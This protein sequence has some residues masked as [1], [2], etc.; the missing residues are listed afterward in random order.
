[1]TAQTTLTQR[2]GQV[3]SNTYGTPPVAIVSGKGATVTDEDGKE[4]I[5]MLAGIAVNSLGYAHPAIVEAVSTQ[6]AT[7]GHVSNLFASKPVVEAAGKLLE[8]VGDSDA[9]VFFSNSG[10][11]ANEAAFK[12]ARLTGRRRIL[13]AHHGFHGRTMGSLA[14]TGQPA[15]RKAFEPFPGGVEFYTYGDID[16]LT[17]LVEQNPEDTSAIILEPIQGET[18][19][20]PAPD[21][22]LSAVRELCTKHGI[23]MIVDEV[24]TGVG[25]TGDFFAFQHE[26]VLPDVITMAKG[27][28]AGMPIGA[29]IARGQ[30]KDLF[31]PGSHGTT[32]GGN[33]VS[34]AAAAT[35]LELVD[36]PFLADVSRKGEWLRTEL[37]QSPAVQSVR[38]RGLMLGVVLNKSVAKDVVAA[39]LQH[40]L[41][42]NAPSS[43][44]V[45]L[46]PPLVITDEELAQAVERLHK[47]LEDFG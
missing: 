29:T 3:L 23:L 16:Y 20:I 37:A 39:G 11:E 7:V 13:A 15:K 47:V 45:R 31:T 33:P 2:W 42:L 1:M 21:G 14:M 10:A 5:D 30:A 28:G 17:T 12:L 24:Q 27:L 41:I 19:V 43:E 4:Y 8:K 6:V 40:G 9:R 32:F 25:R 18:G 26:N 38:G 36:A 35:V 46:T 34:C 44:V 22:F